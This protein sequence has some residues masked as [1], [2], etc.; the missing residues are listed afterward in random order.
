MNARQQTGTLWSPT[1]KDSVLCAPCPIYNVHGQ[2]L[3][4]YE[5]W[6]IVTHHK[7]FVLH[8]WKRCNPFNL[9]DLYCSFTNVG[10][11]HRSHMLV[12]NLIAPIHITLMQARVRPLQN[13]QLRCPRWSHLKTN[14]IGDEHIFYYL[15][16]MTSHICNVKR[17]PMH[18]KKHIVYFDTACKSH[19]YLKL[20]FIS[21]VK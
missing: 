12:V 20:R 18:P 17:I 21:D 9:L 14:K 6:T 15:D 1:C 19:T 16:L 13:S 11:L 10:R 8:Y 3:Q 4:A 5:P 7:K 2:P